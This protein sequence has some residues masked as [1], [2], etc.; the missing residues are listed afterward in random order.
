M[1]AI[2][3]L[4]AVADS[5]GFRGSI[6]AMYLLKEKK[7]ILQ[8][9]LGRWKVGL[10]VEGQS[11][12]GRAQIWHICWIQTLPHRQPLVDSIS[13]DLGHLCRWPK[14]EETYWE[15]CWPTLGKGTN[16]SFPAIAQQQ[17]QYLDRNIPFYI[18]LCIRSCIR[19]I[20]NLSWHDFKDIDRCAENAFIIGE[21]GRSP[22]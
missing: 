18:V 8:Q 9:M 5:L 13:S 6:M 14:T 20:F 12:G 11:A 3:T 22:S 15:W 2:T 7:Y 1:L 21:E 17:P 4:V 10:G 16:L 19:C